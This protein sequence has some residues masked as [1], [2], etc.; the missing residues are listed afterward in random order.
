MV[1]NPTT[2][3]TGFKLMSKALVKAAPTIGV[4]FGVVLMGGG[5]VKTGIETPKLRDELKELDALEDLDHNEYLKQKLLI[6]LYHLGIP[7]LMEV[8][9]AAMIF[10]GYKIKYTQAT[11]AT[12][13]LASKTDE[14]EKLEKKVAEKYGPKELDKIKDDI[15]KDDARTH[16][17]NFASIINTGH[18]NTLCQ[19]AI[20][21]DYY[22]SDLDY[23]R[24]MEREANKELLRTRRWGTK[25]ATLTYNQWREYLDLPMCDE[26]VE[27]GQTKKI[28]NVNIGEDLGWFNRHVETKITVCKLSD[29]TIVHIIGFTDA[30]KPE[31]HLNLGD[32]N[33]EDVVH[34]GY[35]YDDDETDTPWR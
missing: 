21:H 3:K 8:A 17:I 7:V 27:N 31:W 26:T 12:A 4:I 20:C 34:D 11:I 29:D 32:S 30:G 22:W 18:G 10:G 6:M 16:P 2:I 35:N 33:G 28:A 23:I 14:V 9:G 15:A 1:V 13:A 5:A 19:D 24:K 25:K